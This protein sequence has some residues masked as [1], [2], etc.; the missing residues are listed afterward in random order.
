[1]AD[2][3]RRASLLCQ[4]GLAKLS[5]PSLGSLHVKRIGSCRNIPRRLNSSTICPFSVLER[6]IS[7]ITLPLA[8]QLKALACQFSVAKSDVPG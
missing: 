6:A 3:C 4:C 1:M 7:H 8:F 2:S 5:A